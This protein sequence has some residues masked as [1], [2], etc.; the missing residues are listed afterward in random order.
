M[1]QTR[2]EEKENEIDIQNE[3]RITEIKTVEE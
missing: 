1:K 2:K 3:S